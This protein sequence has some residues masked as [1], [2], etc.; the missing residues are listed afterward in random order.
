MGRKKGAVKQN[1][2]SGDIRDRLR[3][4]LANKQN[5]KTICLNMIVR[6]ESKNIRFHMLSII[7]HLLI[8]LFLELQVSKMLENHSHKQIISY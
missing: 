1:K 2:S 3:T 8:S 7:L 4:K 6:N 5:D